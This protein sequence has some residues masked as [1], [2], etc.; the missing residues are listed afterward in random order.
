MRDLS[1]RL[2]AITA[3]LAGL[4]LEQTKHDA[5]GAAA[6]ALEAQVEHALSSAPGDQHSAPWCRSG[7][8]RAS[9]ETWVA[10]NE[11][12]VASTDPVAVDQ[13]LGTRRIPPR[14]F[15]SPAAR[16]A[17]PQIAQAIGSTVE[18]AL[19]HALTGASE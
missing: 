14:P 17:A 10:A 8:L 9:L 16:E 3:R 1:A 5:L 7:K 19:R 11:A 13:E 18:A 15:M 12:V 4:D 2:Q 6:A